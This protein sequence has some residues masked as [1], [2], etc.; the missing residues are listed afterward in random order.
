ML[1]PSQ[2]FFGLASNFLTTYKMKIKNIIL[3]CIILFLGFTV[4][5]VENNEIKYIN[6]EDLPKEYTIKMA[7][8]NG[9]VINRH[10]NITKLNLL[11]DFVEN[12]NH[13]KKALVR[14]LS[15]TDKEDSILYTLNYDGKIIT[16]H[17][18]RSREKSITKEQAHQYSEY[19]EIKKKIQVM[20]LLSIH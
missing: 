10:G 13:K 2:I 6:S 11:D 5:A 16:L 17:N 4:K 7:L 19:K 12:V 14:I 9:D 8:E 3:F 20:P 15:Y 18:D 1:K